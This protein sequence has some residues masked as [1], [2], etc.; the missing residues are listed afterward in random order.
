LREAH[1][2]I[3]RGH[4]G[5]RC[6]LSAISKRFFWRSLWQDVKR[7]YRGCATCA[8]TKTNNHKTYGLLQ[9]LDILD[10]R[11]R[12][13]NID[14]ITKLPPISAGND[15]II[16]FV[17]SLTKRVHWVATQEKT[18]IA[19]KFAEIFVT[20][21][22]RLHCLPDIII[23]NRDTQFNSDFWKRLTKQ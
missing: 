9:P 22:I 15:T 20:F 17:N 23:S 14:F 10:E 19:E 12:R 21:Y 1:D 2:S 18:L 11:W 4:F 3:I 8:R 5:E 7:Y 6:T 16:T 13:I